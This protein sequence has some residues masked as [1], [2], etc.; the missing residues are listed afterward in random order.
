MRHIG[1]IMNGVT[2]RMG[3]NQHLGRSIAAIRKQGGLELKDKSLVMPEPVLLGRDAAKL[4][5]LAKEW[6]VEKWSTDLAACLA[7]PENTIYFDAQSTLLRAD[8]VKSAISAGKHVY[9]EKPLA[10]TLEDSLELARLATE[11]GVKNGVVQD[12]LYLPGLLK[13]K[14]VIASGFLGRVLS[15]RG[16]FGYWVF[17]GP[18]PPAQRPSWN[19]RKEE[20][21][22]IILDMFPHW[23]YVLENLFGSVLSVSCTARTTIPQRV[24]ER[25]EV[26]DCNTDDAAYA[27]FELAGGVVAH[28]NSSW[29]TRVNRDELLELHVDGTEGSA[30]AGLREC[31]VQPRVTTP[32]AVWNPDIPNPIPFRDGWQQVPSTVPEANAFKIQWE[33]FLRHVLEDV[34]FPHSFLN[35]AKGVQLAEAG[36]RSW[37][38]RRWIDLEELKLN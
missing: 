15:V 36:L 14:Q 27:T 38:E 28:I 35:A 26:Y 16:E 23:Q 6:G 10:G 1:I 30:I 34:P 24:D 18:N 7:D 13:L 4:E 37:E 8:A 25:N 31:K 33:M 2:G 20:G 11:A 32:K 5:K 12:K 29:V 22:G 17:E 19:Y 3:T 21:G 9:C